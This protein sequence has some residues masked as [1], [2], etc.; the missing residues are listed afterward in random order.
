MEDSTVARLAFLHSYKMAPDGDG[1]CNRGWYK[2]YR[3][4]L[5]VGLRVIFASSLLHKF[6]F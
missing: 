6:D 3:L 5:R 1:V 4:G 2:V